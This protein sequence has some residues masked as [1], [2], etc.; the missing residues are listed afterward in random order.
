MKTHLHRGTRLLAWR[1]LRR[2]YG[3]YA[4]TGEELRDKW[5]W[6]NE[7]GSSC[8]MP[9]YLEEYKEEYE[10]EFGTEQ[11]A[12]SVEEVDLVNEFDWE[13]IGEARFIDGGV[14]VGVRERKVDVWL[15]PFMEDVRNKEEKNNLF[16]IQS[17]EESWMNESV[18]KTFSEFAGLGDTEANELSKVVVFVEGYLLFREGFIPSLQSTVASSS[19]STPIPTNTPKSLQPKPETF[20]T[21]PSTTK[22]IRSLSLHLQNRLPTL[23][24]SPPSSGKSSTLTHLWSMLHS[25]P[26]SSSSST[27]LPTIQSKK[28]GLVIINLADRSLDSKSLLGSLSSAPS[29][30]ETESGTFVFLEGPLTRAIRQGRWVLLTSIDQAS[31]E[32]LSVI[33]TL[34]ERM[35][36]GSETSIGGAWGGGTGEENGGVGV[37]VGGGEGRWVR[38]GRGF[39][40]FAT[41]STELRS[42]PTFFSSSFFTEIWMDKPEREEIVRIVGGRYERLER[43]GWGD[44]L[45]GI[46]ENAKLV[47]KKES[48]SSNGGGSIREVGVRDLMR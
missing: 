19:T 10:K 44:R 1:I 23:I 36:R 26:A 22:L 11:E 14:E 37:R 15:L 45:I 38:A 9:A 2:W 41:R 39:M 40:L 24:S 5:V 42:E 6:K 31:V 8:P 7:K 12:G 33:K 21:T 16:E 27:L 43:A 18:L 32:V 34:V 30:T 25:T 20:I 4:S 28:R 46:W 35:K 3:L 29:T 13:I 47:G 48:G 17:V